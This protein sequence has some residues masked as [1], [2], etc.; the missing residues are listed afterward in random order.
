MALLIIPDLKRWS[1]ASGPYGYLRTWNWP[2]TTREISQLYN[3]SVYIRNM[4]DPTIRTKL[5]FWL[6]ARRRLGRSIMVSKVRVSHHGRDQVRLHDQGNTRGRHNAFL[7]YILPHFPER[8]DLGQPHLLSGAGTG[9][10]WW[11]NKVLGTIIEYL[12]IRLYLKV[13]I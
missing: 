8:S 3:N 2:I 9:A 7:R 1:R 6:H 5:V 13:N 10:W 4:K 11:H 12:I